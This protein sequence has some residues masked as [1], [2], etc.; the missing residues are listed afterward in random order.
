MEKDYRY[1]LTALYGSTVDEN[2]VGVMMEAGYE[3]LGLKYRYLNMKVLETELEGAIQAI[4]ALGFK[5]VNLTIPHKV[6]AIPMLD[7]LSEAARITGAVN[8]IVNRNGKLRGENTDGVGFIIALEKKGVVVK[9]KKVYI[10]GAGGA[11]RAIGTECALRGAKEIIIANRSKGRGEKLVSM[12]KERTKCD[13]SF[14]LWNQKLEIPSDV[15]ILVNAT[16][17]GLYPDTSKP[18]IDYNTIVDNMAVSDVIF[19]PPMTGFLQEAKA[20]GA[21]TVDGLGMLAYQGAK[22]FEIW[23]GQKAPEKVLVEALAREFE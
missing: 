16:S 7:E 23:T 9:G 22:A 13:C 14:V 21:V 8:V 3:A 11:A 6:K 19:N 12:L 2:P 15:H 10:I 5:G 17:I 18:D 20:Q 4:I 1:E